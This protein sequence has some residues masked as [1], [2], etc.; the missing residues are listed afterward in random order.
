MTRRILLFLFVTAIIFGSCSKPGNHFTISGTITHAEGD[1]IYLE[2]LHTTTIKQI[3][4]TKIHKN[5]QFKFEGRT[6]IPTFYLLKLSDQNFIT[7]LVDS[8][9]QVIVEADAANFYD[10]YNVSGSVGSEQVHSLDKK[11]KETRSK[12]DSLESLNEV[13]KGNPDYQ[14][15]AAKWSAQYDAIVEDQVNFS[16]N[17]V[18]EN[19][20][21]MASVLALYQKFD[22]NNPNYIIRDLQ[23]MRTAASALN[24]IYPNSEQ[25]QALY[26][27]TLQY[28][29]QEQAARMR[30]I[31]EEQG[32]NSPDIVLPDPS[33]KDVALSSL[34]GKPVLLQFWAAVDRN[35]RIQNPV[36]VEL[37]KKYSGKGLQIYQVSVDQNRAEWVDAI[38]KDKLTWINVGDMQGCKVVVGNYNVQAIPYNY[39]LD[40]DGIIVGKNLQGPALDKAVG[41]LFK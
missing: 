35:S 1:S 8:A 27:N 2:E 17:F 37:Y 13:Y 32:Q 15:M 40:K 41:N 6:S 38:D 3:A 34:K 39:L 36:L 7:L 11:L 33:G 10:E 31:I 22:N 30:K 12:L 29:R 23:V 28:V 19:P 25:V 14:N 21:S 18:K 24:S 4:Q 16:T 26:N 9:E 20:F 5:G